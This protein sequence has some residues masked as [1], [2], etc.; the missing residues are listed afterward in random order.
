MARMQGG[1]ELEQHPAVRPGTQA[2]EASMKIPVG[3]GHHHTPDT[4]H[5]FPKASLLP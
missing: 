3:E 2:L 1:G 4:L 5:G